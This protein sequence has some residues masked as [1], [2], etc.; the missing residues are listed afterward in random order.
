MSTVHT[1]PPH[2]GGMM[3]HPSV[4]SSSRPLPSP[5]ST[6]GSPMNGLASPYPVITSSL[7]S[8]SV[9]LPSTPN[10]NF[11]PLN[12]PQ[13]RKRV[14]VFW[15]SSDSCDGL[16]FFFFR[17]NSILQINALRFVFEFGCLVHSSCSELYF[18]LSVHPQMWLFKASVSEDLN[19]I[20]K[21]IWKHQNSFY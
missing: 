14:W 11:G 7:G 17:W 3:G 5:M 20:W 8:P 9:S 16:N 15:W 19:N 1:H 13:V 2:M 4:I 21:D 6:L 10:M 18:T 12:S